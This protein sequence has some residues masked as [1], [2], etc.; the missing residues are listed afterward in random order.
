MQHLKSLP[1]WILW[2]KERRAGQFTKI[3]YTVAGTPAS[4]T[5]PV[6]WSTYESV[7][8]V[9]VG[10]SG[11][12]FV[13]T[14]E[15]SVLFIDLD[16]CLDDLPE[17]FAVLLERAKTYTEVSPSGNGLHILLRVDGELNLLAN[18]SS[19]MPGFE[20]YNT[21]R[22]M[23][24]TENVWNSHDTIRTVSVEEA[25]DLLAIVGY[26]W[27]EIPEAVT[28]A[29]RL[30]EA[31][32]G[33]LPS[34][35]LDRMFA[36]K[37]GQF[38]RALYD[39]DVSAYAGDESAADMGLCMHLAFWLRKDREKMR[40]V[41]LSS[42]LGQRAKTQSRV[43]YQDRTIDAAIERTREVFTSPSIVIRESTGED[44]DFQVNAKG[45]P[46]VNVM[47][48]SIIIQHDAMLRN[49]FRFNDFTKTEETNLS[50]GNRWVP[51]DKQHF[52]YALLHIQ[53]N[54]PFF[55][56]VSLQTIEQAVLH[57]LY[58]RLHNEPLEFVKGVEWDGEHRLNH[59][60]SI[61][62]GTADDE[63]H[64]SVGA[65]WFKGLV[66]RIV[67]PGC[68]FDYVLV[69]EGEQGFRKTTSLHI[70]GRGYHVETVLSSDNKDFYM[71]LLRNTIVEFSEGETLSRSEI[72]NLK[73]VIT[74]QEDQFR[75]PYG[76]NVATFPRHCVFAMTTNQTEYLK[77]ET[78][79]RRW[80]PVRLEQVAD[81]QWLEDN[82]EQLYAE[83]YHRVITNRESTW[84]FPLEDIQQRQRERVID[85]PYEE[86]VVS[87]YLGLTREEK[88]AG[89]TTLMVYQAVYQQ[90]SPLG[91]ELPRNQ[92]MVIASVLR[93]TL[94]LSRNR[95][96]V[97]GVRTYRWLPTDRTYA[98]IGDAAE[99]ELLTKF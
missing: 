99:E 63:Y 36:S 95:L 2:R 20:C 68:K 67:E 91:R 26:P 69:L 64:A 82:L 51:L 41:W 48:V 78:G 17:P 73:A 21:G 66:Q 89:I 98:M 52:L 53:K 7:R 31:S 9:G 28:S 45:I 46:F 57:M 61:V 34:D 13:L 70:L 12:G 15:T 37:N 42:P 93:S 40:E 92:A 65:N 94:H 39:G 97:G 71:L 50:N 74:T 88:D 72:K 30:L 96:M 87:W 47:N 44:I 81:T 32:S 8:G 77:D 83:A 76:R 85:D 16:K 56:R 3:P 90:G 59:W 35:I 58:Q 1:Q 62:Y 29:G 11:I 79:N 10:Y 4:S 19:K 25:K 27:K 60:L 75:V 33:P 22:Y 80:L 38:I 86:Q 5:N 43:D 49:A 84:E 23:T 55:E 54:Y 18:R 6:T 24:V 14:K